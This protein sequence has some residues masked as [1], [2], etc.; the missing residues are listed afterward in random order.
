MY[1]SPKQVIRLQVFSG[2]WDWGGSVNLE[3]FRSKNVKKRK[4]EFSVVFCEG[5]GSPCGAG[6]TRN[7]PIIAKKHQLVPQHILEAVPITFSWPKAGSLVTHPGNSHPPLQK[8]AIQSG[9]LADN[10][11]RL[12]KAETNPKL[13]KQNPRRAMFCI[14]PTPLVR[15]VT[16][17]LAMCS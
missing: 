12:N 11:D 4:W 14:S 2:G 17:F 1:A 7:P 9:Q 5:F 10:K 16:R 3:T 15:Q 13:G 8:T 6:E